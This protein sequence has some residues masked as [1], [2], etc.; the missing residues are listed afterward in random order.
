[1]V[2]LAPFG[3]GRLL[4][5]ERQARIVRRYAGSRCWCKLFLFDPSTGSKRLLH[6]CSSRFTL[7]NTRFANYEGM[8]LG[9]TLLDGRPTVLLLSDSQGGY[10]KAFWHLRDRLRIIVLD[11]E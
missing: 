2:A 7:F 8:C 6:V 1:M 10:G 11:K 3:N 9:P 4:V 5:R